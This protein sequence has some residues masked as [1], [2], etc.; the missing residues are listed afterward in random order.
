[1]I[2]AHQHFW[3]IGK[4]DCTWPTA[5]LAGIY[6]DFLPDDLAPVAATAG[7]T[8]TV[9]VQSQESD[10]DTD[11]LLSLADESTLIK[12]V[13]G[14]VDM[15]SPQ[16]AAR[17]VAL[18]AHPKMRGL[19]PMLQ[20]LQDDSWIL[21]PQLEPAIEAMIEARLSLDA[22]VFTRHLPYLRLFAKRHP[23]LPI[24]IDHGAKPAIATNG[25]DEPCGF[26]DKS[27][28]NDWADSISAVAEFPQVYC[29]LSGLLTEASAGQDAAELQPYVDHLYAV[30]GPDRL[31]W[32]SD[33]PVLALAPNRVHSDYGHWLELAKH[34]LSHVGK[35]GLD[36]VFSE[37][38][39]R[40][41]RF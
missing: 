3:Q 15:A 16:A 29:K 37:T 2:D 30:F 4:H 10:A 21:N 9:L 40:F 32:G 35:A 22:L 6:R 18:A 31:M 19:R 25:K 34:L 1:M 8:G 17:I 36:S 24:V 11:F 14:W 23:S 13:V 26:Y 38:A 33:W 5:D 41:Y 7:V 28:F 27:R 12:A 20:G 39:R